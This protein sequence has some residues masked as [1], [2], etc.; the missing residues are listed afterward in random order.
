MKVRNGFVTNS[1][2][3]SFIISV[4]TPEAETMIDWLKRAGVVRKMDV[5]WINDIIEDYEYD[6]NFDE[7]NKLR[8]LMEKGNIH[9]IDIDYNDESM[10]KFI[11]VLCNEMNGFDMELDV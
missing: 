8:E 3:S 10:E 5:D 2:S 7:A 11:R 1:S 4:N 9:E 6:E